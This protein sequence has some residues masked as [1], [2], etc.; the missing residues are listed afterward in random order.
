MAK[1]YSGQ[2]V[3]KCYDLQGGGKICASTKA[4]TVFYARGK[5]KY[6]SG[7]ETKAVP[8]KVQETLEDV[9]SWYRRLRENE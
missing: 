2:G 8:K 5:K 1:T 4:W 7:F 9:V 3:N 6:G